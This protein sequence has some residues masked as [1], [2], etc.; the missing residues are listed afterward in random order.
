MHSKAIYIIYILLW[1][2]ARIAQIHVEVS[3]EIEVEAEM[4]VS[5]VYMQ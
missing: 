5:I 1:L 3:T 4:C 2:Y